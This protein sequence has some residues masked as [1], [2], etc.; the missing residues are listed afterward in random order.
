MAIGVNSEERTDLCR[1]TILADHV[2][3]D[4]AL[5]AS[6]PLALLIPEVVSVLDAHGD[7]STVRSRTA[8]PTEWTLGRL[9]RSALDPTGSL[10]DH[11]VRDGELLLLQTADR[12]APAPLF[13]DLMHNVAAVEADT[14]RRWTPASARIAGSATAVALTLVGALAV[15]LA[16]RQDSGPT[17][18]IAAL[19]VA[20]LLVAAGT[21]VARVYHDRGS[22]LTL[23]A[24][25]LAPAFAAGALVVPG[26]PGASALLLGTVTCGAFA[27]LAARMSGVGI[28]VAVAVSTTAVVAAGAA[29][30]SVLTD[31]PDQAI[32]A[33]VTATA[34]VL[35]ACAPR[36]AMLL[37]KL[38]LPPVPS[39]GSP[40]DSEE[41]AEEGDSPLPS[42]AG[43]E[44]KARRARGHLTGL[45]CSAAVTTAAGALIA[46]DAFCAVD[47]P[48]FA[49][50]AVAALVLTFRGRTYASLS[51]AAPLIGSGSL[52]LI[53]LLGSAAVTEPGWAPVIL[54]LA[55]LGVGV[56]LALGVVAP[57]HEF[58]PVQRRASELIDYAAIAAVLPLTCWVAGLFAA[59]RGL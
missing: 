19:V 23:W 37:A 10:S 22:A 4:L 6:A 36:I 52:I 16:R 31:L 25:A 12:S 8:G 55:T 56:A 7:P 3:V 33:I 1:V 58:S 48:G 57:R 53:L 46:A 32:G 34:L 41:A 20:V 45:V 43:L 26:E 2:Q 47:W 15:L 27:V 29:G 11:R 35:L 30:I 24:A 38:P 14:F 40:L 5:P 44:E 39:P 18:M 28:G 51:Q 54:V 49:L 13:D 9:G 59:M 17:G 42:F 21:V 50:A